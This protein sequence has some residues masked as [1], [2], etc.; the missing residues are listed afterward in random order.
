VLSL[1]NSSPIWALVRPLSCQELLSFV[2]SSAFFGFVRFL[3]YFD[4]FFLSGDPGSVNR[5]WLS[6]GRSSGMI[7]CFLL[8]VPRPLRIRTDVAVPTLIVL[9][10]L[11][12]FYAPNHLI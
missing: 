1:P 10:L 8:L 12:H 3:P 9:Y 5:E 2:F 7:P 6:M 4:T 11:F